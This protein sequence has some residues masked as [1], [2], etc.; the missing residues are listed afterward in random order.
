[1]A[2]L[3]IKRSWNDAGELA[4]APHASA[5]AAPGKLRITP[6]P[7]AGRIAVDIVRDVIP[8]PRFVSDCTL[9]VNHSTGERQ[10]DNNGG[11]GRLCPGPDRLRQAEIEGCEINQERHDISHKTRAEGMSGPPHRRRSDDDRV[12]YNDDAIRDMQGPL[13]PIAERQHE[14]AQRTEQDGRKDEEAT[15]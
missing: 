13:R 6:V 9:R 15:R 12:S 14:S 11:N 10:E 4:P 8:F 3:S 2:G 5:M 1:M 7:S